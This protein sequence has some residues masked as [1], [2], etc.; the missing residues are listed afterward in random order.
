M[1]A[2][3]LPFPCFGARPHRHGLARQPFDAR[4][5]SIH[6]NV[7]AFT[8]ENPAHLFRHVRVLAPHEPG[9]GLDDGHA[10]AE[11]AIS[12]RHLDAGVTA[13]E[14]DQVWRDLVEF[15]RFDVSEGARLLQ[16][17]NVRKRGMRANVDDDLLALERARAA[18]VQRSL[19]GPGA[20]ETATAHDEFG[21]AFL[22]GL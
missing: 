1:A 8:A 10:A 22:V 17:R 16:A 20:D 19:D 21:T 15:Q 2:F 5:S 9:A 11:A 6:D 4:R 7:D 13:A 14:H 3:D 12:L 18:V